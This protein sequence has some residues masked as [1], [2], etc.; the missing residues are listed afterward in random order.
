[1]GRTLLLA[2]FE[3]WTRQLRPVRLS[4]NLVFIINNLNWAGIITKF[5][6]GHDY[7][8]RQPKRNSRRKFLQTP[9]IHRRHFFDIGG[10]YEALSI[11]FSIIGTY[12]SSNL[13]KSYLISDNFYVKNK[14]SYEKIKTSDL[15]AVINPILG[16]L[17][18]CKYCRRQKKLV[19]KGINRFE[20][21]LEVTSL[22][23]KIN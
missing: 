6:Y 2:R 23:M 14:D 20:E 21:N 3:V 18:N 8:F 10:F 12:F 11:L 17:F 16:C 5:I 4:K 9:R 22:I 15:L 13:F 1:M 7:W 19:D